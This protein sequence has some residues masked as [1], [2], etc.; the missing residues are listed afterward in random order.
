M[1][2]KPHIIESSSNIT[3]VIGLF[4]GSTRKSHVKHH[5]SNMFETIPGSGSL[6]GGLSKGLIEEMESKS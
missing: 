6:T 5:F 1:V 4:M 3:Y 2:K